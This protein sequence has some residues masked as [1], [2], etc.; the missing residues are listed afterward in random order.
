MRFANAEA[1]V[2][3]KGGER[4]GRGCPEGD[5]RSFLGIFWGTSLLRLTIVGTSQNVK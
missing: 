3:E 2:R 1:G 4:G 5:I